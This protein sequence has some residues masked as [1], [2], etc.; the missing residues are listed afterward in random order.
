MFSGAKLKNFTRTRHS[1]SY[2]LLANGMQVYCIW[3]Q[4]T[5]QIV[6]NMQ[7][8]TMRSALYAPEFTQIVQCTDG[9]V[10]VRM[11]MS[12]FAQKL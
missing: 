4:E 8:K 12:H 9:N 5:L 7:E 11:G 3:V 10:F 2:K 6:Q 1:N